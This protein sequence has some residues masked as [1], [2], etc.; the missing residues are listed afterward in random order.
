MELVAL[1]S[2]LVNKLVNKLV[3]YKGDWLR[4]NRG[5]LM[6]VAALI[7]TV[8]FQPAI[9]P[10][11][12]VWQ[13]HTHP[14]DGQGNLNQDVSPI[15]NTDDDCPFGHDCHAGT[16]ILAYENRFFTLFIVFD[17]VSFMASLVVLFLLVIGFPHKNKLSMWILTIMVCISIS[18]LGFT[19]LLGM[20][21]ILP[22]EDDSNG[23]L[24]ISIV[25]LSSIFT[26]FGLVALGTVFMIILVLRQLIKCCIQKF[27]GV[28]SMNSQTHEDVQDRSTEAGESV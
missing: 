25:E 8:T 9:S 13:N 1:P 3:N 14:N 6:T 21:V 2:R 7:V 15:T 26:W 12:G 17:T 27:S 18:S 20:L 11:G 22:D 4:Q 24:K 5:S 10:P 23:P 16:A 19:F 28:D